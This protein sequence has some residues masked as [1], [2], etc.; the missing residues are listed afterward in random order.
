[1]EDHH[2]ASIGDLFNLKYLSLG[3][4][5]IIKRQKIIKLPEN[6]GELQH[7]QTLDVRGT[8]IEE[9]PRTITELQQLAHLYV[10]S[11]TRFPEGT[12]GK[13][14]SLEE[15]RRFG[16]RSYE[17]G[18]SIQEFSKLTKLMRLK[19]KWDVD[20][21][22]GSEGRSQA[23]RIHSYVGNVFSSCNLHHLIYTNGWDYLIDYPLPLHSWHPA[24]SCSIRKL[25]I[26]RIYIY[27]V[28]NWMGSLVNLSGSKCCWALWAVGQGC[29][30]AGRRCTKG[31]SQE[32]Q[33]IE[34]FTRKHIPFLY[35][36]SPSM[37][38]FLY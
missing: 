3:S 35:C 31:T 19:I 28:P 33:G 17:Q 27:T 38:T 25:N 26:E 9:L 22:D 4:P 13:M 2:L 10:D 7:L 12:I 20:L 18:K 6:V 1:M 37:S 32:Y 36:S 15:V 8:G 21:P 11:D 14:Q 24:A 16:V 23:E 34:E 29:S 30:V 5:S